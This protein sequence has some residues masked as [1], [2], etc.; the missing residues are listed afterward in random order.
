MTRLLTITALVLITMTTG[1]ASAATFKPLA[2]EEAWNSTPI[3]ATAPENDPRVFVVERGDS[4]THKAEVRIIK[5]GALQSQPFLTVPNVDVSVERGLLSIAF[6]PDYKTSGRFYVFQVANGPGD[7]I[8]PS[9]TKG[10][11]RI[12][13]YKRSATNPDL[14]DPASG[15]LVIKTPHS[16]GNHNGGWMGFGPDSLLYFTIG[17]NNSP[18]TN[19]QDLGNLYGKVLRI[20]PVG[21]APG[22]YTI[23]PG[24]PYGG[25]FD[26]NPGA[27]GEIFYYGLRNPYR[28]SFS[29]VGLVIGDVGAGQ[30]EE[31]DVL[32]TDTA[33]GQNLGWPTCEG[34]C[35]SPHPEFTEPFFTY[36]HDYSGSP[37]PGTGNVIIGGYVIRDPDLTGLTGRYIYGDNNRSDLRTLNL[38][39]PG[40]DPVDPGLSVNR[41]SLISFGEDS[42]G[43]TY[44]MADGTV[45]R[46]AADAAAPT[47]CPHEINVPDP[48]DPPVDSTSPKLKLAGK[49]QKLRRKIVISATCSENCSI[50]A[51]GS[52]KAKRHGKKKALGFK[53]KRAT[54]DGAANTRVK[55]VLRLKWKAL[56][57]ARKVLRSGRKLRATFRA[58]AADP[59]GNRVSDKVRLKIKRSP[60]KR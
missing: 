28:A 48:P 45:S 39:V 31:V 44:V 32:P 4:G 22:E 26:P 8:D 1:A 27:R 52:V 3:F 2:P 60:K 15:R 55:V 11:I 30:T 20:D 34:F 19:A 41:F 53:F 40:G 10:D 35:D 57:R 49:R 36:E 18:S 12:V 9:G 51:K 46:I 37:A 13:E 6:A 47:A 38:S 21:S 5:D 33:S 56:K 42:L 23:P 24:N 17:D 25:L 58:V 29:N 54:R 43:C 7:T 16:A 59:S 50:S 14:A